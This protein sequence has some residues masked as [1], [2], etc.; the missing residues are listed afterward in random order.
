[1][2]DDEK[3]EKVLPLGRQQGGVNCVSAGH[4]VDVISDQPLQE[5]AR[6]VAGDRQN[7]TVFEFDVIRHHLVLPAHPTRY[8]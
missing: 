4:L 3:I 6:V 2:G 5:R 7:G 8:R 1:M